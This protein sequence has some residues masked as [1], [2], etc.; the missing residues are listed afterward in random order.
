MFVLFFFLL[1]LSNEHNTKYKMHK[2]KKIE[3]YNTIYKLIHMVKNTFSY[4]FFFHMSGVVFGHLLVLYE[5]F[6]TQP[7]QIFRSQVRF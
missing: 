2:N 4:T 5:V 1:M 7:F 3:I 6:G